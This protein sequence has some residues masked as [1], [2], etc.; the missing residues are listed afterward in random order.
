MRREL[1]N[2]EDFGLLVSSQASGK[3]MPSDLVEDVVIQTV[4]DRIT[5]YN[6][7]YTKLLRWLQM[8]MQ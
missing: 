1:E 7:C 5:S 4:Q 6:V 2:L 8:K 3:N